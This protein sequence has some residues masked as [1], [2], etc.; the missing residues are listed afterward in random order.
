MKTSP[1]KSCGA[2][3]IWTLTTANKAMPVN[4]EPSAKGNVELVGEAGGIIRAT[5]LAGPTLFDDPEGHPAR[6]LSHFVTCP[7][8]GEWRR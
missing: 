6:H 7:D 4:A 5:V 1:C 8:A 3:V 2:R